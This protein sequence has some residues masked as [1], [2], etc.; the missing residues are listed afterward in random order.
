MFEGGEI[1]FTDQELRDR[2]FHYG[3]MEGSYHS[4]L[5]FFHVFLG[6]LEKTAINIIFLVHPSWKEKFY[7]QYQIN[8]TLGQFFPFCKDQEIG[9]SNRKNAWDDK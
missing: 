9:S 2:L 8:K 4:N 3:V 5:F 7:I 1:G 6:G